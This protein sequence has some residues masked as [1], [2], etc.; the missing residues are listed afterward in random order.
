MIDD[1]NRSMEGN[2][3]QMVDWL[4]LLTRIPTNGELVFWGLG[5]VPG[6]YDFLPEEDKSCP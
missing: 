3:Q 1:F 5:P 2:I 4:Y 6:I